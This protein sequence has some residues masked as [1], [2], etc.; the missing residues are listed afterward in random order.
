MTTA[1][2]IIR[3]SM[4]DF[5][6]IP[7]VP[8]GRDFTGADCWG[9]CLLA[10]RELFGLELPEYFYTEADILAHACEHIR[11][12]TRGPHW[13]ALDQAQPGDIHIFRIRGFE[14]HCGI[15]I[16]RGDFLHSLAGRNS[17]VESLNCIMWSHC[18][19]GTYR[20]TP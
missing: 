17:C 20:W 8:L 5:I 19:T 10:A 11:H 18:R 13:R 7:Y 15:D 6:G 2:A 16:G 1:A 14:V 3:H 4:I 9:V 12:A